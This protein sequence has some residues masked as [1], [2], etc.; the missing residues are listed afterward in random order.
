[1]KNKL[2]LSVL[3]SSFCCLCDAQPYALD[4]TFNPGT[5]ALAQSWPPASATVRSIFVQSNGQI[6]VG[7]D[8]LTFNGQPYNRVVRL[9]SDG[10]FDTNF[11]VGQGPEPYVFA[12]AA[13]T[14]GMILVGGSFSAFGGVSQPNLARLRVDGSLDLSFTPSIN[15]YLIAPILQPGNGTILIT[16]N[17]TQ[18]NSQTC[19]GI[20]RLSSNGAL[21]TT[22]SP[23][24]TSSSITSMAL[25]TNGNILVAGQLTI[26]TNQYEVVR[27]MPDG[28]LDTTFLLGP[29]NGSV[30]QVEIEP[31]GEIIITGGFTEIDGYSRV[32]IAELLSDGT[33]DLNF[34]PNSSTTYGTLLGIEADGKILTTGNGLMRANTDGSVDTS[35]NPIISSVDCLTIQQDGR[36]L[37]GGSFN[38]VDSTNMWGIARLQGDSL[39][40]F[41]TQILNLNFYPGMQ[42]AGSVGTVYRI[43]STTN[44]SSPGLWTP[45]TTFALTTTPYWFMD[46]NPMIPNG[47][48]FYRAVA[49][50]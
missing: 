37:I 10:S 41:Q 30:N 31:D 2:L 35:F 21:D 8:F 25:D 17:F 45:V 13:Q 46:T 43:E 5:G 32:G 27:L 12:V 26:G 29:I 23:D 1:M 4:L 49:L 22:F 33:V 28:A 39:T 11:Y 20:A 34:R 24:I 7:G 48:R 44:L 15:G 16:G 47:M 3:A 19:N 38:T 9:N 14:N 40:P 42:V 36:F 50:P 6:I 18:V